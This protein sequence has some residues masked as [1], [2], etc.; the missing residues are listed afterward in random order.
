MSSS[1]KKKN[2]H[3]LEQFYEAGIIPWYQ[4]LTREVQENNNKK[5]SVAIELRCETLNKMLT[6]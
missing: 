1:W 2:N 4:N 5:A 6:I 3:I